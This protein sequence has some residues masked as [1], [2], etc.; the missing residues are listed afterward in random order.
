VAGLGDAAGPDGEVGPALGGPGSPVLPDDVEDAVAAPGVPEMVDGVGRVTPPGGP[1]ADPQDDRAHAIA[2]I[3][4]ADAALPVRAQFIVHPPQRSD[5]P[6]S[7]WVPADRPSRDGLGLSGPVRRARMMRCA[8]RCNRRTRM[9]S[10]GI[11][12]RSRRPPESRD[13]ECGGDAFSKLPSR[14]ELIICQFAQGAALRE[15]TGLIA[16]G[17]ASSARSRARRAGSRASAPRRGSP[18]GSTARP[19]RAGAGR[20]LRGATSGNGPGSSRDGT[21]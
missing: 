15:E 10:P 18:G 8:L 9:W 16:K 4:I 14:L 12:V 1:A 6:W 17:S 3:A 5:A 20:R 7:A 19:C 11:R 13:R 2:A 21:R